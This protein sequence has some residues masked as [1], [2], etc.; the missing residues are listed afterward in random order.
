[1]EVEVKD[2][3]KGMIPPGTQMVKP[4]AEPQPSKVS[5]QIPKWL[6][7]LMDRVW[8][9]QTFNLYHIQKFGVGK[10]GKKKKKFSPRLHLFD[11]KYS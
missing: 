9:L 2:A 7:S 8:P 4:K 3:P 11:K 5:S 6:L 10:I 1:M